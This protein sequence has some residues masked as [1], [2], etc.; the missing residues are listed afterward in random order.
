M[1]RL[2][3]RQQIGGSGYMRRYFLLVLGPLLEVYLHRFAGEDPAERAHC[4]P[5]LFNLTIVLKGSYVEER[6][7]FNG[8][9]FASEHLYRR[10][11]WL[12]LRRGRSIHRIVKVEPGTY[13]LFF[14][15]IRWRDWGFYDQNGR[16]TSHHNTSKRL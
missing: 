10:V 5:W 6:I 16:F 13:T 4:H 14:G 7:K 15:F 1:T 2:F 11:R 9:M 12:C 3:K 8:P